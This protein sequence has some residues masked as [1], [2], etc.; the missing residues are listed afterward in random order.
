MKAVC[1]ISV[2]DSCR[3]VRK[4]GRWCG[5]KRGSRK[6][7]GLLVEQQFP[8]R[9]V[10]SA[11]T[12]RYYVHTRRCK[13]SQRTGR[14]SDQL[15]YFLIFLACFTRFS[16]T[17]SNASLSP[18]ALS[19]RFSQYS[20]TSLALAVRSSNLFTWSRSSSSVKFFNAASV[21]EH[22]ILVAAKSSSGAGGGPFRFRLVFVGDVAESTE[23]DEMLSLPCC[24]LAIEP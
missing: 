18:K 6:G 3:Y 5:E 23:A 14:W 15:Y 20:S 4:T 22:S 16:I 13:Q 8:N 11:R 10:A 9:F 1:S 2:C 17:P 7:L 12:R 24:S 21:V 19:F